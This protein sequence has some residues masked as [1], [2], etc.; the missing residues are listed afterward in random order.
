MRRNLTESYLYFGKFVKI[1]MKTN[2]FLCREICVKL[3][4]PSLCIP[5]C[6]SLHLETMYFFVIIIFHILIQI[7][8]I[9]LSLHITSRYSLSYCFL[10]FHVFSLIGT[11]GQLYIRQSLITARKSLLSACLIIPSQLPIVLSLVSALLNL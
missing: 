8:M 5:D 1:N 4:E 7:S 3:L 9:F 2:F 6:L 11:H 10:E